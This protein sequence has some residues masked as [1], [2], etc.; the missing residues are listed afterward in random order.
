MNNSRA[1]LRTRLGRALTYLALIV[2][3]YITTSREGDLGITTEVTALLTFLLPA[4]ALGVAVGVELCVDGG[5]YMCLGWVYVWG[6]RG[7]VG[8]VLA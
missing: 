6:V 2:V 1:R 8:G 4:L 5:E 3:S 7:S